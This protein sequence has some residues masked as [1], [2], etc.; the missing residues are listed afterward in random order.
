M[1]TANP[2]KVFNF[3]VEI[4]G[5]VQ[6]EVQKC[7]IPEPEIESVSHGASNHDVKTAGRISFGDITLEK[8]RAVET[9]NDF[10]YE[11]LTQAQNPV[12]GGGGLP[13]QYKRNVVIRELAP[14][15]ITTINQWMCEG[16]WCKKT[17]YTTSDRMAGDNS[18][19]TCTISVDKCY[20]F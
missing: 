6:F 7:N 16:A 12:T 19:E 5:L 9:T 3:Q 2:R 1:A 10:G 11:W 15:N 17:S 4:D 13:A 20:P 18:I 8:L 14:N